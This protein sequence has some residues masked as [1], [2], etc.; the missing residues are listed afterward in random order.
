M[1]K[2]IIDLS[3]S[4]RWATS[5]EAPAGFSSFSDRLVYWINKDVDSDPRDTQ[6]ANDY[7]DYVKSA[8]KQWTVNSDGSIDVGI[9]PNVDG[10]LIE[11]E[12]GKVDRD[13]SIKKLMEDIPGRWM[14]L[15]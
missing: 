12:N 15:K 14:G 9:D 11:K 7:R 1:K 4:A 3:P 6:K 13:K 2:D 10:K 8:L 5:A